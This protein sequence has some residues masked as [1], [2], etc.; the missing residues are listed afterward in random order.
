[1]KEAE[2]VLGGSEAMGSSIHMKQSPWKQ[3]KPQELFSRLLLL[4]H[5]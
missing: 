1:M 3:F 2:S 4:Q 5:A